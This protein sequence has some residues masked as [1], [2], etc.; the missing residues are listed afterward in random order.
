MNFVT[1]C[2]T[3]AKGAI[4]CCRHFSN[5]CMMKERIRRLR[6]ATSCSVQLT[7]TEKALREMLRTNLM[8]CW[9]CI[10]VN[11]HSK[12][13]VMIF[14]FN[15]LKIT[16]FYMFRALVGCTR[17]GVPLQP[18]CSQEDEQVMFETCRGLKFLIHWIKCI[19]L[20][21]LYVKDNNNNSI[22]YARSSIRV[23]LLNGE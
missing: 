18:W 20:V 11:Q 21:L 8:F 17:F 10:L 22:E 23:R 13:N 7:Y 15:L 5:G 19:T 6:Q 14:L 12:T 4:V 16:G 9:P 3:V 1:G 2:S